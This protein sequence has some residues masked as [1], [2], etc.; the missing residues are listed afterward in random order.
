MEQKPAK[1]GLPRVLGLLLSLLMVSAI[2]VVYQRMSQPSVQTVP[3]GKLL[4]LK[5]AGLQT[6]GAPE[7]CE[8]PPATLLCFPCDVNADHTQ[9]LH[10]EG[11]NVAHV[12]CTQDGCTFIGDSKK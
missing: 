10:R 7:W 11:T 1:S 6:S 2:G 8:H 3:M 12:R 5:D 9:C 4:S